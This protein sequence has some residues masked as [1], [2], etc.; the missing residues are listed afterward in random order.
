MI[1]AKPEVSDAAAGS[2]RVSMESAALPPLW[3]MGDHFVGLACR[4]LPLWRESVE[5]L[6]IKDE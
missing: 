1:P 3:F 4:P 2:S 5:Y 6:S